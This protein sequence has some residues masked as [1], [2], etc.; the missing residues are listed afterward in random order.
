[1]GMLMV[2]VMARVMVMV[3][4]RVMVIAM[5]MVRVIVVVIGSQPQCG[6]DGYNHPKSASQVSAFVQL[7]ALTRGADLGVCSYVFSPNVGLN[8]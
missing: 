6:A 2:V 3:M 1:M 5:V 7:W 4:I 8:T